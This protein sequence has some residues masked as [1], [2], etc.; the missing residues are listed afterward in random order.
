M[1]FLVLVLVFSIT[2]LLGCTQLSQ[3]LFLQSTA[4]CKTQGLVAVLSMSSERWAIPIQGTSLWMF[5]SAPWRAYCKKVNE[6]RI[7]QFLPL[8]HHRNFPAILWAK[9]LPFPTRWRSQSWGCGGG[10]VS[11]RPFLSPRGIGHSL[12]LLFLYYL[13]F[14]YFSIARPLLLQSTVITNNFSLLSFL[15]SNYYVAVIPSTESDW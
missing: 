3:S 14:S 5:F 2:R 7:Y 1:N 11:W 15:C 12:Y 9:V 13:V 6:D 10:M 8:Q 4:V